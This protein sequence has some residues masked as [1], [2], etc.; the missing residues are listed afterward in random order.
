MT[1][2][3]PYLS[4]ILLIKYFSATSAGCTSR[5][6]LVEVR[7]TASSAPAAAA[8]SASATTALGVSMVATESA[9][10]PAAVSRLRAALSASWTRAGLH[11]CDNVTRRFALS[12]RPKLIAP[13]ALLFIYLRYVIL[14]QITSLKIRIRAWDSERATDSKWS[15]RLRLSPGARV[16][17]PVVTPLLIVRCSGARARSR[18]QTPLSKDRLFKSWHSNVAQMAASL[19]FICISN[20]YWYLH[21][22]SGGY[23]VVGCN[24]INCEHPSEYCQCFHTVTLVRVRIIKYIVYICI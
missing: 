12:H 23:S 7:L 3:S 5:V 1:P 17:R 16:P 15:V 24:Q 13:Q 4:N 10:A 9:P 19:V 22:L 21:T 20:Q 8:S 18:Q 6:S 11:R 2:L 14:S